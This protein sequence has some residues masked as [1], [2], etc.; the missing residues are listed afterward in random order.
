MKD[1]MQFFVRPI[2][3]THTL[4]SS[5]QGISLTL[6]F[7]S[8]LLNTFLDFSTRPRGDAFGGAHWLERREE[9]VGLGGKPFC[10]S[11]TLPETK[12]IPPF[13]LYSVAVCTRHEAVHP[14]APSLTPARDGGIVPGRVRL[15]KY[16]ASSSQ[17][18]KVSSHIICTSSLGAVSLLQLLPLPPLA[19]KPVRVVSNPLNLPPRLGL[20]TATR[21]NFSTRRCRATWWTRTRPTPR[22]LLN[23]FRLALAAAVSNPSIRRSLESCRQ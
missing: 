20:I 8:S 16:V 14:R 13:Q 1:F 19:P 23:R 15:P 5:N 3:L 2:G 4:L 22:S 18:F 6:M 11:F 7:S 10:S 12:L 9:N 21:V 17:I